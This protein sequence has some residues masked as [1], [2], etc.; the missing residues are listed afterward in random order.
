[1][2][3]EQVVRRLKAYAA[4]KPLPIGEK[5]RTRIA[6]DADIL[7]V[8]FVRMGGESSPWG[9]AFGHPNETPTILTIPE[10][11]NRDSIADM[12]A[13]FAT[14]LL[15]HVC[16]PKHSGFDTD[17]ETRVPLRQ[18]WLANG[19]HLEMLHCLDYT[20][21]RTKFGSPERIELLN[22]AGRAA[23]WLFR[24]SQRVGTQGCL[25]AT[26]VLREA[27][28]FPAENTRQGHLGFLLG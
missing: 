11:R 25:A 23:G 16:H 5:L 7:I 8:A 3:G 9:I 10:A 14:S 17:K 27:Y 22:A 15:E 20:Y 19:S 24:E 2:T 12:V 1:M 28:E 18:V 4:G 21:T 13:K 26:D 6:P